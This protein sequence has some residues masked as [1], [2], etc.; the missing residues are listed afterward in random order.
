MVTT[1]L[2]YDT[3]TATEVIACDQRVLM[4]SD[5][6]RLEVGRIDVHATLSLAVGSE[7]MV[8]VPTTNA[9]VLAGSELILER[10]TRATGG[11]GLAGVYAPFI[12]AAEDAEQVGNMPRVT[13]SALAQVV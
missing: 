5:V 9:K 11:A 13:L 4:A 12:V 1:L 3:A 7:R 2:N 10:I 8:F 6:G